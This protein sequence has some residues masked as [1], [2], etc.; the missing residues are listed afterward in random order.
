[1]VKSQHSLTAV[2]CTVIIIVVRSTYT[3]DVQQLTNRAY[4]V[5]YQVLLC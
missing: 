1:M 2:T 4:L 3:P 5:L